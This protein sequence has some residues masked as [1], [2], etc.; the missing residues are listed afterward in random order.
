MWKFEEDPENSERYFEARQAINATYNDG[1]NWFD[2]SFEV[3]LG[4]GWAEWALLPATEDDIGIT[5]NFTTLHFSTNRKDHFDSGF[6]FKLYLD[7]PTI[8]IYSFP[9][10]EIKGIEY[11][12]HDSFVR[13]DLTSALDYTGTVIMFV[14]GQYE[15]PIGAVVGL[16][17]K[18]LAAVLKITQGQP[19]SRFDTAITED[20]HYQIQRHYDLSMLSPISGEVNAESDILF[21]KLN[22]AAG[23]HCGLTKVVLQ[24]TLRAV[25]WFIGGPGTGPIPVWSADVA[26]IITTIYIPWFLR[27]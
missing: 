27:G 15:Q 12:E 26:N 6:W 23:K 21:F 20:H 25:Q 4:L 1:S 17:I 2:A 22:S 7:N 9:A 11:E 24:G 18:G 14:S 16:G 13:S 3:G 8:D 10:L 19:V 5:L